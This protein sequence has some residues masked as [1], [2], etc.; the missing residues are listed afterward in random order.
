MGLRG[1]KGGNFFVSWVFG[2]KRGAFVWRPSVSHGSHPVFHG[3]HLVKHGCHFVSRGS[4]F[5]LHGC[6]LVKH[7]T[8]W[9]FM[10]VI[11]Y[12]MEVIW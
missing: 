10:V 2:V 6:R 12:C 11:L 4:H 1:N 9:H 5:V 7:E 8:R 3:C